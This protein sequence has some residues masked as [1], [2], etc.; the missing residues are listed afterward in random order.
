MKVLLVGEVGYISPQEAGTLVMKVSFVGHQDGFKITQLTT[1]L[2]KM[3]S[4]F[5]KKKSRNSFAVWF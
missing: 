2:R 3:D 5:K 4:G 1:Q